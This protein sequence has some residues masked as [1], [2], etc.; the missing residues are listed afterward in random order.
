[1]N[2]KEIFSM[3]LNLESPWYIEEVQMSKPDASNSGQIDIYIN[4]KRGSKFPNREG[5]ISSVHDTVKRSWQHLNF[6]EH[7]CYI[8]ARVPRVKD[9]A[10]KV[11]TVQ[12]PWARKHSGF[13]LLYEAYS[14]LLIESEMPVKRAAKT[15]QIY[16]MR[17][18]RIFQYWVG[19]AFQNS[20]QDNIKKIGIDETSTKKGHNYVTIAVDMEK[21]QVI[22][23]TPGKDS[24]CL[25]KL[26]E[27]L[28]VKGCDSEKIEHVS[29][30]MSPAFISGVYSNFP[31]AKITYDKFHVAKLVNEA[32]DTVRK[33]ERKEIIELKGHKYL[34]LKNH[35]KLNKAEK[36]HKE[37]LLIS[38]PK[39]GEAYRLKALFNDFWD[40]QS[41]EEAQS[42][43]AYWC[44]LAIDS[45]MAPFI[46]VAQTIRVHW[47]GIVNYTKSKLNNGILE[48][49]N[50]KIQLAKKRARGYKNIY[51]FIYMIY[52]IAGKLKFDYPLYLR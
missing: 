8:H 37:H 45:A 17:L 50:S 30:D 51:N 42:Y 20:K 52:F 29:I 4:F 49:I 21:R 11:K 35:N 12:V 1:M 33:A 46:K 48:G 43:L 38:Y 7:R 3:A 16:E 36:S 19:R 41:D 34:F 44:D 39:L 31:N 10:N 25:S 24:G 47:T 6:F 23:A 13:T 28:T 15:L 32:M 22:Y 2:S 9:N 26:K 40:M 14:M 27:H 18:W 5:C